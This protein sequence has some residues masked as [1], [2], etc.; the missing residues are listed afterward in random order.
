[1]PCR[2]D[3]TQRPGHC[4]SIQFGAEVIVILGVRFGKIYKV[5]AKVVASRN[6]FLHQGFNTM[7]QDLLRCVWS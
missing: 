6:L 3:F 7:E 5:C 2:D 4:R 1:M